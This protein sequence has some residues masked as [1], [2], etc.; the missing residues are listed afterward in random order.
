MTSEFPTTPSSSFLRSHCFRR[1]GPVVRW[2][3]WGL[4]PCLGLDNRGGGRRV[5]GASAG[6][7]SGAAPGKGGV[8]ARRAC[9]APILTAPEQPWEGEALR[10]KKAL[11]NKQNWV[12]MGFAEIEQKSN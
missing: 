2:R 9:G 4:G 6:G 7:G 12:L 5:P 1:N 11:G 10:C 3:R 8:T